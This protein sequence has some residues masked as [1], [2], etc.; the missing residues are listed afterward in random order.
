MDE[1]TIR[2]ALFQF[3]NEEA[4]SHQDGRLDGPEILRKTAS[5]LRGGEEGYGSTEGHQAILNVWYDLF[6]TGL[7]VPGYIIGTDSYNLPLCHLSERG[8]KTLERL[9]RD[10]ANPNGYLRYLKT[11]A[12]INPIAESYLVEALQTYNNACFKATAVMVGGAAES[13]SLELRDTLVARL[14]FLGKTLP[15]Q[16]NDWK[17][18]TVL[19][20]IE[21]VLT[22]HK[23]SMPVSLG[24]RFSMFW[25]AFTGQIRLVR[26]DVG[27]PNSIDP[28]TPETVHAALLAFP[29]V[30]K[31][32]VE[33]IGWIQ[34]YGF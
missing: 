33:L 29:D 19:D 28:V 14:T 7:L 17:I 31:I 5:Y 15:R 12:P 10:P 27:H 13:I 24:E 2:A 11:Q 6:R 1:N 20:A 22:P 34:T 32:G 30:A 9:S 25:P 23:K 4:A 26:N 21:Q 18:K 8:R 3:I 16:L